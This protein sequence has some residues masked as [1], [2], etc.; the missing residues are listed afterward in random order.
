MRGVVRGVIGVIGVTDVEW[1]GETR[2]VRKDSFSFVK[3][4]L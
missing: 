3:E 2:P 1:A 4:S